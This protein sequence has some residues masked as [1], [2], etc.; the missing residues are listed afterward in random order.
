MRRVTCE[1]SPAEP[2]QA[3]EEELK[4]VKILFIRKIIEKF[5]PQSP[6]I[7]KYKKALCSKSEEQRKRTGTRLTSF[8]IEITIVVPVC[9]LLS[10]KA[11]LYQVTDQLHRSHCL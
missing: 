4:Y 1:C 10:N 3:T 5:I 11:F 6:T 2:T 9:S 8:K 7:G